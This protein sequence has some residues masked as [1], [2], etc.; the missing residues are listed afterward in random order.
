MASKIFDNWRKINKLSINYSKTHYLLIPPTKK[1]IMPCTLNVNIGGIN[2]CHS[3]RYLRITLDDE[4][5]WKPQLDLLRK[6]LSQARGIIG[7]LQ[8]YLDRAETRPC[9]PPPRNHLWG[10][11]KNFFLDGD[12]KERAL[13]GRCQARGVWGHA[14][15]RKFCGI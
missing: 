3:T 1:K 10:P 12:A 8:C 5:N 11:P 7:K 13:K 6:Q 4:L 9:A 14:S 2:R 15:S